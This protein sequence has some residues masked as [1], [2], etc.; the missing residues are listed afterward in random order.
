[1]I[2]EL[3]AVEAIHSIYEAQVL[4]YLR[5]TGKRVGMVINF[6]VEMLKKGIKRLIV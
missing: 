3:K 2:L 5:A 6:N 1:M 4:T